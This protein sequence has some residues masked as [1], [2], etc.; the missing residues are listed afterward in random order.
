MSRASFLRQ[1]A[2]GA[3]L[4]SAYPARA[5]ALPHVHGRHRAF[6]HPEPRPGITAANVLSED[7]L[8]D[9]RGVREAYA[10]ARAHPEIFDGL[11]CACRC[12]KSHGHRSL[13]SCFE[14]DQPTGCWGCQEEAELV[15]KLLEQGKSLAQIRAAVDEEL[16]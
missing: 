11:Y 10:T 14:S 16:G 15:A 1:L 5:F 12:E 2:L 3:V 6:K 7:K 8:P 13:L 9:K 4:L